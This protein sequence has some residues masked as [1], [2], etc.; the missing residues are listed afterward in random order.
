MTERCLQI[1]RNRSSQSEVAQRDFSAT[2]ATTL[3]LGSV[4]PVCFPIFALFWRKR[5]PQI[6]AGIWVIFDISD[7]PP[8]PGRDLFADVYMRYT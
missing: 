7:V 8:A 3:D 5:G 6:F 2:Q 4:V 1:D